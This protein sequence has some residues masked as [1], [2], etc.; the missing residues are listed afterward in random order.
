MAKLLHSVI[1]LYDYIIAGEY[2]ISHNEISFNLD[3]QMHT[4]QK[5]ILGFEY[6][7]LLMQDLIPLV[8][9]LFITMVP[10]HSDRPDRQLAFMLNA[11]RL[12]KIFM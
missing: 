4:L 5:E 8:V 7:G 1:G 11:K 6:D 3:S 9:L 10:L 2:E 12:Y